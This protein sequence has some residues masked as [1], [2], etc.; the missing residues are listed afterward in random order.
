[1]KKMKALVAVA[2]SLSVLL[3]ISGNGGVFAG[4]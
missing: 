3:M 4:A 1:M 2:A